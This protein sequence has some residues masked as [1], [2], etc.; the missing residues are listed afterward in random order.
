MTRAFFMPRHNSRHTAAWHR[1]SPFALESLGVVAFYGLVAV[2][3]TWPLVIHPLGGFYG[4]G[5]DNW[6]GIPYLGW[7]HDTYLGPGDPSL[8]PEFQAPFGLGIPEHAM[9]PM[10]RLFSLVFGGFEQGLGAYNIQIFTSFVLAGCTMY[11]AARYITGSRLAAVVAGFAFTF[12]P[13]HLSLAMQYNALASIQ[14]IPLY[15]LALFILLREGRKL[16]AVLTGAAFGL[17]ALTS[18]YYA[19]F[20]GWFTA[21][22][23]LFFIVAGAA[24]AR[25]E[26]RPLGPVARRFAGLA[27]T[28][29]AIVLGVAL[30]IAIPFL[31]VSARGAREAGAGVIEHPITEGVRYS[32]RPWMFF[33]PPHDNPIVGERVRPWVMAHIFESPVYEQSMYL[34]YVLIVLALAAFWR[35]RASQLSDLERFA[36]G[37]LLVGA[38][39]G[40]LMTV[41]PYI[42]LE[43]GYWRNWQMLDATSQVPSLGW[44]MFE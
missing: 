31:A 24:R 36:R 9:Q 35:A 21:I 42:P 38:L 2:F 28:R 34:G 17:V 40:L 7:L 26:N 27:L 8:D 15:I 10:D 3:A 39:A 30:A 13:F 1:L 29:G 22:V 14:W 37:L 16:H 23:V 25:R 6:G 12:S 4:F 32:A 44:L 43:R 18:Y 20:V 19:W 41:G 11:V 5:N 33:V